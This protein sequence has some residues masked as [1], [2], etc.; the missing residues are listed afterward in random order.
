M[1]AVAFEQLTAPIQPFDDVKTFKAEDIAPT[2]TWGISP[3]HG[4]GVG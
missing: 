1:S 4:V 3:D 2:V